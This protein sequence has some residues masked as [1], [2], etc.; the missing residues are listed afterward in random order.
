MGGEGDGPLKGR[1]A[2][3][4]AASVG[5]ALSF[6]PGLGGRLATGAW[7]RAAAGTRKVRRKG[8]CGSHSG[9]SISQARPEGSRY[10]Q[11]AGVVLGV[12]G[13]VLSGLPRPGVG[14]G[15]GDPELIARRPAHPHRTQSAPPAFSRCC[16]GRISLPP[17]G[18][19]VA[20]SGTEQIRE[21]QM[22]RAARRGQ[23]TVSL[24]STLLDR[25]QSRNLCFFQ[26]HMS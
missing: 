23:E 3:G 10:L 2:P 21:G 8:R 25:L 7:A 16:W 9:G 20:R 15:C 1:L 19:Q 13:R 6:Q 17:A 24:L 4:R 11:L 18:A 12:P 26:T 22:G 14:P 5:A